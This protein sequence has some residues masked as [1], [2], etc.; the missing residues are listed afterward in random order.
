MF[1]LINVADAIDRR[2][3]KAFQQPA[4]AKA[5][6]E[7]HTFLDNL[8]SGTHNKQQLR[9][10]LLN[11]L[12]AGRDTSASLL[13]NTWFELAQQP[14]VWQRLHQEVQD[15]F[16]GHKPS[17]QHQLQELPYLRAILNESMRMYPQ[18]AENGRMALED[19]VLPRG[20]GADGMSSVFVPKWKIVM[21][22]NYVLQ[23][24]P[25]NFGENADEFKPE[26]WL[27][28]DGRTDLKPGFAYL[29]FG[30]GPRQC[31]GRK[32]SSY[33]ID[34]C[35]WTKDGICAITNTEVNRTIR[36]DAG[37][38]PDCPDGAD[39]HEDTEYEFGSMARTAESRPRN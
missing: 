8:L 33:P 28:E 14:R 9:S 22:G 4:K 3:D 31:M 37:I 1:L 23:R 35:F 29:A 13:S 6:T 39:F 2:L 30:A 5:Q 11:N 25:D 12:M 16:H 15:A 24:D 27:G 32:C 26:R 38:L 10:E 19:T 21:W 7:R 36:S 18:I 20:G 34:I 17:S